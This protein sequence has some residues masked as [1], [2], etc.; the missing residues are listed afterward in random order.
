MTRKKDV[1]AA[2]AAELFVDHGGRKPVECPRKDGYDM[3]QYVNNS[4]WRQSDIDEVEE[5]SP[6]STA[7]ST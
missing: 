2:A 4:E 7:T 6:G 5:C 1:D 3:E